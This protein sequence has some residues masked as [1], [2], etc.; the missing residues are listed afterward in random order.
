MESQ[1]SASHQLVDKLWDQLFGV[2]VGAV[3]VIASSDNDRHAKGAVVGFCQKLCASF[4]CSVWVCR[5]QYLLQLYY[6]KSTCEKV[7]SIDLPA[8]LAS[9]PGQVV[10]RRRLHL[11]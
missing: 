5:F 9:P 7:Y 10:V 6:F 1:F 3:D 11:Y 2:L 8:L 4:R